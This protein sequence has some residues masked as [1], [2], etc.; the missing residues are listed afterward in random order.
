MSNLFQIDVFTCE[1]W[2]ET[3]ENCLEQVSW[4]AGGLSS[5][6]QLFQALKLGTL[7]RVTVV[8]CGRS[9]GRGVTIF[10]SALYIWSCPWSGLFFSVQILIERDPQH[11]TQV[12]KSPTL[13]LSPLVSAV[14]VWSRSGVRLHHTLLRISSV[15]HF[16]NSFTAC[17]WKSYRNKLVIANGDY[18]CRYRVI[19]SQLLLK[20]GIPL[21][22]QV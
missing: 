4:R 21:H 16:L 22:K 7:L 11:L 1:D 6:S 14:F 8:L 9:I 18:C 2:Q 12:I 15:I 20:R 19:L 17:V 13:L 10:V 3:R 5:F